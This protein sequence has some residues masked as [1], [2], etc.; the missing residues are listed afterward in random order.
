MS[1]IIVFLENNFKPIFLD[2]LTTRCGEQILIFVAKFWRFLKISLHLEFVL[3]FDKNEMI[4]Q[5]S[6]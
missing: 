6:P 5:V 4:R 1:S 2:R 3:F